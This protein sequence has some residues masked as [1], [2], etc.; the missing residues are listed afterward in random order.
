MSTATS[1]ATVF[2]ADAIL[3][4]GGLANVLIALALKAARP[5]IR[6]L[7]LER[8]P[9]LGANHT[10]SFHT[11]DVTPEQMA[12]LAPMIFA[13]W[14]RQEVRFPSG[15]RVIETGYN[16]ISSDKLHEVGL[17]HLGSAVRLNTD[18]PEVTP[19]EVTLG[20]GTRL[21]APLVIDGR[22]ALQK[23]PL[24]LGYQKFVGLEV[25]TA[26][27]HGQSHPVIMDATVKQQD[28]YRFVYTLPFSATHILIEDT[29]YSDTPNLDQ[30]NLIEGIEAYAAAQ[31]W[32]IANVVRREAGVLPI[33]LAGRIDQH[34]RD[35][36]D[37]V[38]R[39]GLRA[40]LFH[41]TTGYSLPSAVRLAEMIAASPDLRSAHVAELIQ[42]VSRSTWRAQEIFRLLNRFLF[43]AADPLERVHVLE[44]FY[45]L[46][47]GVIERFYAGNL[48]YSDTALLMAIM[49][50]K[51]PVGMIRA[52]KCMTETSSWE[53]AAR[54][55]STTSELG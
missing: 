51:P 8:G 40:W 15:G 31:G 5:N 54:H 36:G 21:R 14:P 33:T 9:A 32:T 41:A 23:Q 4:G 53:F 35:M 2:D 18:V 11:T 10:W 3:V 7:V 24:A 46:P 48:R 6:L 39:V 28:G 29:Y 44:R 22:G 45:K 20:D 16:S 38:P 27:P 37:T 26:R 43:L 19:N 25:E 52:I 13:R 50:A 1:T 42:R 49:A 34:W 12:W 17:A 55:R 30:P 47:Q